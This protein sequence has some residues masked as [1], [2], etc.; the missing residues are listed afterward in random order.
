ME[1]P[2]QEQQREG[3]QSS[4]FNSV[5]NRKGIQSNWRKHFWFVVAINLYAKKIFIFDILITRS[6]SRSHDILFNWQ[7]T[8]P[9]RLVT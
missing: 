9:N 4:L 3:L 7:E 6:G 8:I 2:K 1:N 5:A